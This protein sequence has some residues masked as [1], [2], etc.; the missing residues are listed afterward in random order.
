MARSTRRSASF[1]KLAE[2]AG[3]A[4][5]L[6]RHRVP[7]LAVSVLEGIGKIN[8]KHA[9]DVGKIIEKRSRKSA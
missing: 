5:A 9:P 3:L 8:V 2:E 6:V 7:E 1:E 4:T